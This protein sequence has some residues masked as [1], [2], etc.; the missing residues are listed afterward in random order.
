MIDVGTAGENPR[1]NPGGMSG[2]TLYKFMLSTKSV[3]PTTQLY[4]D[5]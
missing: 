1:G 4:V 3:I 2:R 5:E